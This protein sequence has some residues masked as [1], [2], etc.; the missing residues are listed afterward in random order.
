MNHKV[1][2]GGLVTMFVGWS[3]IAVWHSEVLRPLVSTP[4]WWT[5]S[6]RWWGKIRTETR[7]SRRRET[8]TGT[9]LSATGLTWDWTRTHEVWSQVRRGVSLVVAKTRRQRCFIDTA[10]RAWVSS[11]HSLCSCGCEY[12]L[13]MFVAL[14][15]FSKQWVCTPLP[16]SF[17]LFGPRSR[18]QIMYVL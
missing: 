3:F 11:A 9:T 6:E 5:N 18:L 13:F 15:Q 8:C 14:E 4:G 1:T 12:C 17:V 7:Q 10:M 2:S 16:A